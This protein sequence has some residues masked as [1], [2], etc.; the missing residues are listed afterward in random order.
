MWKRV[1]FLL[2]QQMS[3]LWRQGRQRATSAILSE[4]KL[5]LTSFMDP[6][7]C[8]WSK[9]TVFLATIADVPWL[10]GMLSQGAGLAQ[11][12]VSMWYGC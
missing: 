11:D 5:L 2:N 8:Y 9:R 1:D 3:V 10:E 12:T 7:M 4:G 6:F